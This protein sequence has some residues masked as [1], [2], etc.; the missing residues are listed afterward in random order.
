MSGG[1]T[2]VYKAAFSKQ[3]DGFPHYMISITGKVLS[4]IGEDPIIMKPS[5]DS[6]GYLFVNLAI[7]K[8]HKAARIHRLVASTFLGMDLFNSSL[9][10]CHKDD[11]PLNNNLA[12]LFVGTQQDNMLDM[13][14]KG[15]NHIP[16]LRF[17]E[18]EI[19]QIRQRLL[20]GE[21][22]NK[23]AKEFKVSASLISAI[24]NNRRYVI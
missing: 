4:L 20:N 21:R 6:K 24:R 7:G 17:S 3:I 1:T 22:G 2:Q 23:L 9:C 19:V 13:L 5:K 18:A 10:V 16:D 8:G 11:N 15:H 12:N 14:K